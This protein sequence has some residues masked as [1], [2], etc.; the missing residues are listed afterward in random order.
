MEL[1]SRGYDVT[2]LVPR[3]WMD[4]ARSNLPDELVSSRREELWK[5]IHE[6]QL[7]EFAP[8]GPNL[9]ELPPLVHYAI[10][11]RAVLVTNS[12]F[13]NAVSCYRAPA[14]QEAMKGWLRAWVW[15]FA[16]RDGR[17]VPERSFIPPT[18]TT[19][20][21]CRASTICT[22]KASG[23]TRPSRPAPAAAG[24]LTAAAAP[25]WF[26]SRPPIARRLYM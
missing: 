9:R 8:E 2:C 6:E 14:Q 3:L 16:F 22:T 25:F 11:R 10:A 24:A 23:A 20:P 5:L 21:R 15:P 26:I 13:P 12:K 7:A 19:A 17:F 18:L 1:L 4:R